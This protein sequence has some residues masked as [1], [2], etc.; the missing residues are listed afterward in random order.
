M[1]YQYET[2]CDITNTKTKKSI[3]A[4]VTHFAPEIELSVVLEKTARINLKYDG[5]SYTG[6]FGGMDFT[7]DGPKYQT[8]KD[9]RSK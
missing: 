7:S 5:R 9:G 6:K 2:T 4:V 3:K 1:R 8:I